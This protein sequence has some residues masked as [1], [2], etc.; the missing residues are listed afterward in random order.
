MSILPRYLRFLLL[1]AVLTGTAHAEEPAAPASSAAAA[2]TPPVLGPAL[3]GP[4]VANPKPFNF[5]FG[6]TFLGPILGKVYI[7]GAL[8]GLGLVQ[9]HEIPGDSRA[10]ADISNGQIFVQKVDGF[11]NIMYRWV[12]TRSP[13]SGRLIL[14]PALSRARLMGPCPRPSPN[15][16]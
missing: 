15:F 6:P 8:S 9:T 16:S 1:G 5:D 7:T 14:R 3:A 4:L 10:Q 11:F 12:S 2:P 13:R